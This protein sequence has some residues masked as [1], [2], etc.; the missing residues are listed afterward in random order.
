MTS[1][2]LVLLAAEPD[3]ATSPVTL[4]TVVI[5]KGFSAPHRV[6]L[7]EA[8]GGWVVVWC[9]R[10]WSEE[11]RLIPARVTCHVT[12]VLLDGGKAFD[13]KAVEKTLTPESEKELPK[14][15]ADP[16]SVGYG[17]DGA[18]DREVMRLL[19][20]ACK[21]K[22]KEALREAFVELSR[23]QAETCGFFLV[24]K[25]DTWEFE[26][27][28]MP[29]TWVRTESTGYGA[30]RHTL[31]SPDGDLLNWTFKQER[32][33]RDD[34]NSELCKS[35]R[36]NRSAEWSWKNAPLARTCRFFR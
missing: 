3:T 23:L 33:I 19:T 10:Q 20:N 7:R 28:T 31:S 9:E 30:I 34:C 15:C 32:L 1:I 29:N 13:A 27:G 22:S 18:Y 36:P 8:E 24:G 11:G 6:K 4:D 14:L 2:L 16:K 35:L 26:A 17:T 5:P 25:P 12:S 21:T